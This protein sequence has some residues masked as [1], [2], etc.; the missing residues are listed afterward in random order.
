MTTRFKE[1]P[2]VSGTVVAATLVVILLLERTVSLQ[3]FVKDE[4]G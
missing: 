2:A 1:C 4:P 3:F